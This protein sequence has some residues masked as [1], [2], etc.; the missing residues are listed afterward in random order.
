MNL[1]FQLE[2][3]MTKEITFDILSKSLKP[4]PF[5]F[6]RTKPLGMLVVCNSKGVQIVSQHFKRGVVI[7]IL[8]P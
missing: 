7:L 1:I 3:L 5:T 8:T 6:L 4:K 2:I